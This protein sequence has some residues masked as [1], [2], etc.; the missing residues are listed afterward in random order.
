[1]R[2]WLCSI[3]ILKHSREKRNRVQIVTLNTIA[4]NFYPKSDAFELYPFH[5]LG[6]S[7]ISDLRFMIWNSPQENLVPKC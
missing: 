2:Q 1:M 7:V 4:R 5:N 6:I 3:I